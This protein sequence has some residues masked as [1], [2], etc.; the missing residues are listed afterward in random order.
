MSEPDRVRLTGREATKSRIPAFSST[1]EE[2][3]FWDTH[4][5]AEFED[6]F[7]TVTDV[8]FVKAKRKQV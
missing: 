7:E 1:E 3:E 5:S 4:D 8:K 2:A 6:E